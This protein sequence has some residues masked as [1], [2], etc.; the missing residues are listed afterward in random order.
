MDFWTAVRTCFN[1]YSSFRGRATRPEFWWFVLFLLIA[2]IVLSVLDTAL[3]GMRMMHFQPLSAIFS[4]VTILPSLAVGARRL[5][6]TGRSGWWQ[7]LLAIPFLGFL[8]LVWFLAQRGDA[9]DNDYG[10]APGMLVA[11]SRLPKVPRR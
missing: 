7:L 3:F 5:H 4:L 6:D 1:K 8:V 9:E 2:N 11:G 10:P